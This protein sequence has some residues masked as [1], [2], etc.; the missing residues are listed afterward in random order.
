MKLYFTT[1]WLI[2]L[3]GTLFAASD[4]E[5]AIDQDYPYLES[6]YTHLHRNPEISFHEKNTSARIAS[7]LRQ[8]GFEVTEHVG[9]YGVVGVMRNG[10]GPTILLRT[11]MDALPVRE[12]TG[13]PYASKVT[14]VD[15]QG[16][17]VSVMHACGHDIHMTVFVGTARRLNAMRN[18][19][20]GTIVMI[21]QP[22]EERGSGARA[23]LKDGLFSRFP[24]PDYNLGLH[25]NADAPAG[26]VLYVPGYAM[27]NV[28]SVD[29]T[30]HGIGGH[31]AYPNL[32]KDPIVLSAQIINAL[33]T[34]VSREIPPIEAGVVTVGSI[35]GGT[36]HN[37]IP[38]E[39]HMQLTVRSYTD[40]VRNKLINGIKRIAKYQAQAMGIPED[41]LPEV[42]VEDEHTPAL[43]NDP[44][45]TKRMAAVLRKKLGDARVKETKPV[46]GGEDFSEYGRVEPRIPGVF[47]WLGAVAPDKYQQSIADGTSLPSLHSPLFA[48][49]PKPTIETGVETMVTMALELLGKNN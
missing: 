31:G 21:G 30:V 45:L 14:T 11:D 32:T 36:K 33:Q 9:G 16:N 15:D 43:Y 5:S 27:A 46:M 4:L 10:K 8:S 48:P 22:A 20:R 47:L 39:V 34:L 2:L 28:D 7:E 42:T 6:L 49:L 40:E 19:W 17:E 3:P 29:I 1:L 38:D 23:M 25:D 35:H 13:L 44:E 24:R 12:M 26:T 18:Q 37:I 41:K